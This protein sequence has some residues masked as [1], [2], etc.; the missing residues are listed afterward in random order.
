MSRFA[1]KVALVTGG[2]TGIGRAV[3]EALV[4][5]SAKVV[6][7]GRREEPLKHLADRFPAAVRYVITDITEKGASATAVRFSVEQFGR[8]DV[9]VNNAGVGT[10]GPLVELDDD[11]LLQTY[12]V[13]V[14]GVLTTTREPSPENTED[15]FN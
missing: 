15:A 12:G 13:N 6:V 8:L 10:M 7:T 11:T 3:A 9:L 2:G 5:E 4:A 1:D 14:Q